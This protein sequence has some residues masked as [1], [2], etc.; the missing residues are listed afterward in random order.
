MCLVMEVTELDNVQR[1]TKSVQ[2]KHS[3]GASGCKLQ[4]RFIII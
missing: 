2:K 4:G 3:Q 1:A